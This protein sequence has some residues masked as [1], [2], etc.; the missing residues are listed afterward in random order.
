[1]RAIV[2]LIPVLG[3]LVNVR[4]SIV[5]ADPN[6]SKYIGD[7][8]TCDDG[9]VQIPFSQVNDD[10]CD[11]ADS[12][13]EPG[14]SA[15]P[16]G[17]FFCANELHIPLR[18]LT[19]RLNDGICDCCDGTDESD[20]CA[21]TCDEIGR[22]AREEA[23][24][25]AQV[26]VE[27]YRVKLAM[28][29]EVPAKRNGLADE[30]IR[31]EAEIEEHVTEQEHLQSQ[32]DRAKSAD[33]DAT[34]VPVEEAKGMRLVVL[35]YLKV[36]FAYPLSLIR[37]DPVISNKVVSPERADGDDGDDDND[38][39]DDEDIDFFDMDEDEDPAFTDIEELE[40]RVREHRYRKSPLESNLRKLKKQ[41]ESD[42][43]YGPDDEFFL[44]SLEC[45]KYKKEGDT[46]EYILC[47]FDSVVQN[48]GNIQLGQ[49][50]DW[51]GGERSSLNPTGKYSH[52]SY[53]GGQHCWKG[54]QRSTTVRLLCD[55]ETKIDNVNEPN[56]CVYSMDLYTPLACTKPRAA[57]HEEL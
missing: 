40:K 37:D 14:T 17:V 55:V 26:Q 42:F 30:I 41:Q 4:A 38:N 33:D 56:K 8:F 11:C 51:T 49:S 53:T 3:A 45:L 27:G 20:G 19:S 32:L 24:R 12:S 35:Q 36:L 16:E 9:K 54:P 28:I 29:S 22:Q 13:D 6:D 7:T 15:C 25:V 18:I 31:L 48:P 10:Y 21:N 44:L 39:D 43:D 23:S 34:E 1:M 5:G 57:A 50:F 52:M 47:P 46:F 2:R